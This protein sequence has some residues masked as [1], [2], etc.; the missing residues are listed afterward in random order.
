MDVGTGLVDALGM[1][2]PGVDVVPEVGCDVLPDVA[3]PVGIDCPGE[4]PVAVEVA[5]GV[6]TEPVVVLE[7][8]DEAVEVEEGVDVDDVEAVAPGPAGAGMKDTAT[9]EAYIPFV[10]ATSTPLTKAWRSMSPA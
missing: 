1:L 5:P 3:V 2:P 10:P 9:G 6:W 4:V 8:V 7:A